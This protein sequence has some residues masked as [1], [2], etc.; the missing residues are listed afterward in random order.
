MAGG[1]KSP[2]FLDSWNSREA[3]KENSFDYEDAKDLPIELR[4][5]EDC[6]DVQ[7]LAANNVK[8][9]S[10]GSILNPPKLHIVRS[11]SSVPS[12]GQEFK[13]SNMHESS[14]HD[15]ASNCSQNQNHRRPKLIKQ[16]QSKL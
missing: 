14:N 10:L 12:L 13:M 8:S 11:R 7:E 16:K 3:Q 9:R 1:K 2:W 15:G 6:G 5:L 4:R